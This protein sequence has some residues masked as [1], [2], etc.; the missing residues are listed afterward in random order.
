MVELYYQLVKSGR[1]KISE[2]PSKFQAKV[3]KMLKEDEA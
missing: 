3:K 1:R 2:V